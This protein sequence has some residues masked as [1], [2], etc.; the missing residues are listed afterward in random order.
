MQSVIDACEEGRILAKPTVLISNNRSSQA[1][2][3]AKK[4]GFP[5]FCLNSE[6]HPDPNNL[7][8]VIL[9]TLHSFEVDLVVLAGYLKQVGPITIKNFRGRIINIHPSLLPKYGGQGMYGL[10]VHKAVIAAG[11]TITGVTVHF[12]EEQ[13]DQGEIIEQQAVPIEPC[14]TP[15][16]LAKRVLAVEYS[17]LIKTIRTFA[18]SH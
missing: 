6:S 14:D 16:S 9:E 17:L 11:E 7:D 18:Y 15:N 3:R 12:V 8:R 10:N 4:S 1:L 13:Y 5:G 2:Q